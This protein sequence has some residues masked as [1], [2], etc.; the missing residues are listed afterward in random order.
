[1]ICK[2][3]EPMYD[4]AKTE[5]ERQMIANAINQIQSEK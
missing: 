4:E 5:H 2:T 3:V 1:M